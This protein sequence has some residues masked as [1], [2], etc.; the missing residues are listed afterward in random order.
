[1]D[2]SRALDALMVEVRSGSLDGVRTFTESLDPHKVRQ[3]LESAVVI[4]FKEGASLAVISWM[5]G[6]IGTL[7][8]SQTPYGATRLVRRT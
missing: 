1:M 6:R 5:A 8:V 2:F 7:R 4:G 3:V